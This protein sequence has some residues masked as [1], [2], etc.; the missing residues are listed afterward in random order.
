M[1]KNNEKDEGGINPPAA[2]L[3]AW[4]ELLPLLVFFG[5]YQWKGL[6]PATAAVMVATLG[7][8]ALVYVKNRRVPT[9]LLITAAL[10]GVMG[11]LTLYLQDDQFIKMKPTLVYVLLASLLAGGEMFKKSPLQ[12]VLGHAVPLK[13]EGWQK[14]TWR[15]V[16]FFLCLASLNEYV[17][18][19]QPEEVWVKVRVFGYLGLTI[20][21][22]LS[23][24]PLMKKYM[25]EE[26]K[27]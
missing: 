5:V 1:Q 20:L 2:K 15:W 25:M 23:Q 11:S 16:V 10:V 13:T 19:T 8:A 21:F 27:K 7:T 14:L 6:M 17:W 3:P 18:R 4:V 22:T 26:D 9:M 12:K 24:L